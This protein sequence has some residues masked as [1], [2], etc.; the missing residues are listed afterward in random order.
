MVCARIL[1]QPC[2]AACHQ[3]STKYLSYTD[4]NIP[5]KRSNG[6]LIVPRPKTT[7]DSVHEKKPV[8]DLQWLFQSLTL[9]K[10]KSLSKRKNQISVYYVVSYPPVPLPALP[11]L[12]VLRVV[13]KGISQKK[14][15][16]FFCAGTYLSLTLL[17]HHHHL[18][19]P[20]WSLALVLAW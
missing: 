17:H 11:A 13:P 10:R 3:K 18:H 4:E 8:S 2:L 12:D 19:D 1:L 7:N 14:Y 16:S 5:Q 20:P 15:G 6:N 9:P